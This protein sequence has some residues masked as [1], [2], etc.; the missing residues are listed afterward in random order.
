VK[1]GGNTHIITR[2]PVERL[3]GFM[4]PDIMEDQETAPLVIDMETSAH[5]KQFAIVANVYTVNGFNLDIVNPL[6]VMVR[7]IMGLLM[8]MI[9]SMTVDQAARQPALPPAGAKMAF[10]IEAMRGELSYDEVERA[11]GKL[12]AQMY[13]AACK[14]VKACKVTPYEMLVQRTKDGDNE[15]Q[16]LCAM[17]PGTESNGGTGPEAGPANRVT[18]SLGRPITEEHALTKVQMGAL[19]F[20]LLAGQRRPAGES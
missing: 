2:R 1:S 5:D 19:P 11:R 10:L 3:A 16:R 18:S 7:S 12:Y 6:S 17:T 8:S 20:V 4:T 13:M 14:M 15:L 9:A